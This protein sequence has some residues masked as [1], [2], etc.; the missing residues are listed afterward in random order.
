MVSI[1]KCVI[2]NALSNKCLKTVCPQLFLHIT[3][4]KELP[5]RIN[6]EH[7]SEE[8]LFRTVKSWHWAIR[9]WV[10]S[11]LA[12]RQG[13]PV[14]LPPYSSPEAIIW[15][16][17][18]LAEKWKARAGPEFSFW[19]LIFVFRTR[20]PAFNAT[21]IGIPL[22][23]GRSPKLLLQ[24]LFTKKG[25]A[26]DRGMVCAGKVSFGTYCFPNGGLVMFN[27]ESRRLPSVYLG[28][29]W[30]KHASP[31]V[32]SFCFFILVKD[33]CLVILLFHV[34]IIFLLYARWM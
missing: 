14:C 32:V 21:T 30:Y 23:R 11:C 6:D 13:R 2:N 19:V 26:D 8:F 1:S 5:Q 34:L 3:L 10:S 12:L 9:F 29:G 27:C 15:P 18:V 33:M 28:R 22:A 31:R 7:I 25:Y 4:L 24:L 20:V 16:L 17:A